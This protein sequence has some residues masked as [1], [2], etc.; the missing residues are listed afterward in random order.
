MSLCLIY[1]PL[2]IPRV[3]DCT[4]ISIVNDI[5]YFVY[6]LLALLLEL[7]LL[8]DLQKIINST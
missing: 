4:D 3:E 5:P 1:P 2:Y 7:F 8:L 6:A